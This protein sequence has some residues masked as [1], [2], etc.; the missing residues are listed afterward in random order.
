MD[1]RQNKLRI[2]PPT[3]EEGYTSRVEQ[4]VMT[5]ALPASPLNKRGGSFSIKSGGFIC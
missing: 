3:L 2:A 5:P 4:D 1:T